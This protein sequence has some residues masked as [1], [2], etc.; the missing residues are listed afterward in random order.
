LLNLARELSP[1]L[2]PDDL[3]QPQDFPELELNPSFR[4]EE[5]ILAGLEMVQ[6]A[7]R[8]PLDQ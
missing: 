3:L 4:Y 1:H 2:T 7:L 8:N 5:G 6:I